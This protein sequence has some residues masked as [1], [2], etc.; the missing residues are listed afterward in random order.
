MPVAISKA[1]FIAI[2]A[3]AFT[4]IYILL[5]WVI[6]KITHF[7]LGIIFVGIVFPYLVLKLLFYLESKRNP[8]EKQLHFKDLTKWG[9]R[10]RR[11]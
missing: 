2:I 4:A 9:P 10:T 1:L 6:F 11:E 3:I 7:T 8:N 5:L